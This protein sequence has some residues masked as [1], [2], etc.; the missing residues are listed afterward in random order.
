VNGSS[1]DSGSFRDPRGRVFARDGAVYRALSPEGFRHWAHLRDSRLFRRATADGSLIAT[2]EVA[3]GL[4][5]PPPGKWAAILS[6]QRVPFISYPYEWTFGM[7]KAAALLQLDLLL[8]A[9][10]E[11]LTLQDGSPF[12][13]Q[14]MGCTPTFIDVTSFVASGSEGVWAGYRQFCRQCLYPLLLQ[15]YKGVAFGAWLR[16]D[17]DGIDPADL[18]SLLSA[19]D[20]M[21]RGIVRHVYLHAKLQ[22]RY[23]ATRRNLRASLMQARPGSGLVR[24]TARSLKRV[25]EGLTWTPRSTHW[26][27]YEQTHSYRPDDTARKRAFVDRVVRARRRRTVWDLGCNTGEYSRL[28]AAHAEYVVAIDAD[29]GVADTLYQ[30]LVR[31][32]CPNILPLVMSATDP[33]PDLGWRQAERA[34]LI[35]RGRP[36]LVLC[37]ALAHHVVI[38]ANVPVRELVEFVADLADEV[39]IEFVDRRDA[40][41]ERLLRNREDVFADYTREHFET[42]LA[43]VFRIERTEELMDGRRTLYHGCRNRAA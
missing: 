31:D 29:P 2:A 6:H 16:G 35:R 24:A 14:W 33:S 43:R 10:D 28:A 4:I 27:D 23:A 22:T 21:R 42:A 19:R 26:I 37:L 25:I 32:H 20:L 40:M 1:F 34:G 38:G 17:L 13:V 7:L 18:S 41:V 36:E 12:N 39:V 5:Q 30:S 15:A 3:D 11:G 9:V 8:G